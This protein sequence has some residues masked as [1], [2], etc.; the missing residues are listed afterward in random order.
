[1]LPIRWAFRSVVAATFLVLLVAC[2]DPAGIDST[3]TTSST[4][5]TSGRASESDESP[6][7]T[8]VD[9]EDDTESLHSDLLG[10]LAYATDTTGM[11][12]VWSMELDGSD[13]MTFS[14]VEVD[15]IYGLTL[16]P[17][18]AYLALRD[19]GGHVVV[20][21]GS[22]EEAFRSSGEVRGRTQWSGDGSHLAYWDDEGL[23]LADVTSAVESRSLPG[24]DLRPVFWAPQGDLL[25]IPA[26]RSGVSYLVSSS[27]EVVGESPEISGELSASAWSPVGDRIVLAALSFD[28]VS[29]VLLVSTDGAVTEVDRREGAIWQM[30]VSPD[31]RLAAYTMGNRQDLSGSTR[32]IDL[33]GKR[34]VADL[35]LAGS[36][37]WTDAGLAIASSDHSWL[38]SADGEL[39]AD[40]EH[41]ELESRDQTVWSGRRFA[42]YG[43]F[44]LLVGD[45]GGTPRLWSEI[46]VRDDDPPLFL[47]DGQTLVFT[48]L[49][50]GNR[51]KELYVVTGEGAQRLTDHPGDDRS[52]V[53]MG[54]R[55]LFVSDRGGERQIELRDMSTGETRIV[56]DTE[57]PAASIALSPDLQRLAVWGVD[58]WTTG[59][60]DIDLTTGEPR[61]LI[62]SPEL[63][64]DLESGETPP[65]HFGIGALGAPVW[66]PSGDR[67]AVPTNGGVGVVDVVD[68][69]LSL[70]AETDVLL[71][72]YSG[73][74]E[75]WG[76]GDLE[77]HN[78]LP[79]CPDTVSW[80]PDGESLVFVFPCI[81]LYPTGLW[82]VDGEGGEPD[83]LVGPVANVTG[84]V[85]SPN[86]DEIAFGHENIES[87]IPELVTLRLG[88]GEP[89]TVV[90]LGGRPLWSPDGSSFAIPSVSGTG[91]EILVVGRDGQ[92]T[93]IADLDTNNPP[94]SIAWS[95]DGKYLAYALARSP[96]L[97]VV[98]ASG[99]GIPVMIH[100]GPV[101][102]LDWEP[103]IGMSFPTSPPSA[104][105]TT[106]PSTST[107]PTT[108]GFRDVLVEGEALPHWEPGTTDHAV[109]LTAPTVTGEDWKRNQY[110]IMEDGRPKVIVFFAHWCSH[111]QAEVPELGEWIQDGNVPDSVDLYTINVFA[112][113]SRPNWPPEEWLAGETWPVPVIMDDESSAVADAYGVGAVPFYV[114]LDGDNTVLTRVAG[115]MGVEGFEALVQSASP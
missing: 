115:Q 17:D 101:T 62:S 22:G 102:T 86:G 93:K 103:P 52:P 18:G 32:I 76:F 106:S 12:K 67:I 37:N 100:S 53:L 23:V 97:F 1:M 50:D 5:T 39:L 104:T 82:R 96:G 70:P 35:D 65:P 66:S 64:L 29:R 49:L 113:P 20:L 73:L 54:S 74:L 27:G 112:H 110:G 26:R 14:T 11:H 19:R 108:T 3:T 61:M 40:E 46:P 38:V 88:D 44:G 16:S 72:A 2:M 31:G 68:G 9:L 114:V 48:A 56:A 21:A 41:I 98:D 90:Q 10:T 77:F 43:G 57:L 51:N 109:G 89:E 83:L 6:T 55:I 85:W 79:I 15:P 80:S 8:T 105:T 63:T 28:G 24:E 78:A 25:W 71:S 45:A 58:G 91:V 87:G 95:P 34:V 36:M 81:G 92:Q 33:D 99:T 30:V 47:D 60:F 111:C 13:Q 94:V 4:G 75:E 59:L 7:A 107:R 69:E 42:H 84:V